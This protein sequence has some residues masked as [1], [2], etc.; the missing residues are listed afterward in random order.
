MMTSGL[1]QSM[2][3]GHSGHLATRV[4]RMFEPVIMRKIHQH[5]LFDIPGL[6]SIG[7]PLRWYLWGKLRGYLVLDFVVIGY[8]PYNDLIMRAS[9]PPLILL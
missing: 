9:F 2:V 8:G 6:G 4:L 7:Q 5:A 3:M 1:S